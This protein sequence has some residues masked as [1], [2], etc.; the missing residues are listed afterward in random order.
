M[1]FQIADFGLKISENSSV[2]ERGSAPGTGLSSGY[3]KS[4]I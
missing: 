1:E 4:S 3:L 2:T